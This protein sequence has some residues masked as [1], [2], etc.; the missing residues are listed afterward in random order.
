MSPVEQTLRKLLEVLGDEADLPPIGAHQRSVVDAMAN[1]RTALAQ[2][3]RPADARE[4]ELESMCSDWR[5][6][7]PLNK[8]E[9]QLM[10]HA[11]YR[12]CADELEEAIRGW[13][14]G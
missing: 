14:A 6:R 12:Q 3:Q 4:G 1:A 13:G 10:R 7:K 5:G 8:S 2:P 9:A 11:T